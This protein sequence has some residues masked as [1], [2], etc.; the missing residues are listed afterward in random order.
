MNAKSVNKT[1][2]EKSSQ[3]PHMTTDARARNPQNSKSGHDKSRWW[4]WRWGNTALATFYP[5]GIARKCGV[6]ERIQLPPVVGALMAAV[7]DGEA[8]PGEEGRRWMLFEVEKERMGGLRRVM[9]I[10]PG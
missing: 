2:K 3:D 5:G 10:W 8:A 7:L 9:V 6:R 4:K 1:F